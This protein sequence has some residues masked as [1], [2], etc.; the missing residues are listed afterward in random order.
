MGNARASVVIRLIKNKAELAQVLRLRE[1]VFIK[2][3]NVPRERERDGLDDSSKH[4]IVFY[5]SRPIGCARVRLLGHKAKLERIAILSKYQGRGFGKKLMGY[6]I[7]Y[8]KRRRITKLVL[9]SQVYVK[10]FYAECGFKPHGK[11]FMDAGIPH[12]G[13]TMNQGKSD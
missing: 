1:I 13:M 5:K 2:G 4:V 10:G 3:Q 11:K 6:L 8:C 12:I 7:S 9:H